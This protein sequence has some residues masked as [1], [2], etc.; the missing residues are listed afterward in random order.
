MDAFPGFRFKKQELCIGGAIDLTGRSGC[1]CGYWS[2]LP[3]ASFEIIGVASISARRSAMA[4]PDV[5]GLAAV[6]RLSYE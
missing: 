6:Y 1:A 5:V 3:L 4:L 2:C